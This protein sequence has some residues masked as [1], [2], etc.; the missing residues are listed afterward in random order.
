V[1][2]PEPPGRLK[3]GDRVRVIHG[4]FAGL[5]ALYYGQSSRARVRVLL[6]LLGSARPVAMQAADIE[7]V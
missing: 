7:A 6:Q 3:A 4:P 5:P 2:L 1:V